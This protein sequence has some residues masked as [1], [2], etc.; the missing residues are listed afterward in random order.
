[1]EFITKDDFKT[2]LSSGKIDA[3][4]DTDDDLINDAIASGMAQAEG[5]LSR[6]DSEAIW[7]ASLSEK[8]RKYAM[9]ITWIKDLVKWHFVNIC[10]VGVDLELAKERYD[11]AI[12]E[13]TKIQKGMIVPKGWPLPSNSDE[14]GIFLVE[15]N[16]KRGNY[17]Y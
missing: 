6:F 4:S 15:S 3:I 9:L 2:H 13:L 17:F 12:S 8:K 1:M 16:L 7:A 14:Q 11:D 5:Y 10:N